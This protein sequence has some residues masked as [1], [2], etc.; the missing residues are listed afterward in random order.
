M[1]LAIPSVLNPAAGTAHSLLMLA[2]NFASSAFHL[3]TYFT[4]YRRLKVGSNDDSCPIVG[5]TG[6]VGVPSMTCL[7]LVLASDGR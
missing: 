4:K 5:F 7:L 6:L 2:A 1:C 3:I